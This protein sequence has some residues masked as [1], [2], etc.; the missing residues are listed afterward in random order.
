ML[1]QKEELRV[2]TMILVLFTPRTYCINELISFDKHV[3]WIKTITISYLKHVVTSSVVD[4]FWDSAKNDV[5]EIR[6]RN[7]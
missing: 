1:L 5:F 7:L 3:Q 6:E 2:K 4:K